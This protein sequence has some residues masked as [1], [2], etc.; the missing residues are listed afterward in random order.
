VT[1]SPPTIT[2][3]QIFKWYQKD[4]SSTGDNRGVLS[5]ITPY[6]PDPSSQTLHKLLEGQEEVKVEYEEYDWSL[7]K[8]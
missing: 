7:N 8:K 5:F 3:S 1:E 6:L 4:F 2:L